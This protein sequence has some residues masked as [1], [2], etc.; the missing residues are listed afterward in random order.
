MYSRISFI[1]YN[2]CKYT[3]GAGFVTQQAWARLVNKDKWIRITG[4]E[5]RS[6]VFQDKMDFQN[7]ENTLFKY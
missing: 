4:T 1:F 3:F 5:L 2:T 6:Q 7:L